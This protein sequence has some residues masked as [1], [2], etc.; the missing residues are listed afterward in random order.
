MQYSFEHYISLM[1]LSVCDEHVSQCESLYV[2]QFIL[3]I[4]D[5][6]LSS[7]LVLPTLYSRSL[8]CCHLICDS[9]L[10]LLRFVYV[11]CFYIKMTVFFIVRVFY[12][13]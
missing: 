6:N 5:L 4:H 11:T 13:P 3:I 8:F 2:S 12:N 9:N 1:W 7:T 10:K